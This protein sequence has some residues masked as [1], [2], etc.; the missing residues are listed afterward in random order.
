[1]VSGPTFRSAILFEFNFA[2]SV[3]KWSSVILLHVA[4]LFFPVPFVEE[5]VFFPLASLFC[6]VE[7]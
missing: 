1:M 3:R 6:F 7:N 4:V 2:Y 5:T